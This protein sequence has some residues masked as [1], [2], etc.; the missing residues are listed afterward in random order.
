MKARHR[1]SIGA[2]LLAL[3]ATPVAAEPTHLVWTLHSSVSL[4]RLERLDEE[5]P[6]ALT[7]SMGRAVVPSRTTRTSLLSDQA[8]RRR[9]DEASGLLSQ[10]AELMAE[11][12][13]DEA[14][15]LLES[16][17]TAALD[18]LARVLDAKLLA[19][20]YLQRGIAL[21]PTDQHAA[22]RYLVLSLQHQ[23]VQRFER[24]KY[25]PK[26]MRALQQAAR[27][28]S[29]APLP[30]IGLPE[31]A[32]IA[33]T[34]QVSQLLLA[35]V[36]R[37]GAEEKIGLSRYD[38]AKGGWAW[39]ARVGWP[40]TAGREQIRS[41]IAAELRGRE[42]RPGP[43]ARRPAS[44][45]WAPWIA[46]GVAGASL[47]AGT[48]CALV[49]RARESEAE[50]LA[51]QTPPVEYRPTVKDLEVSGRRLQTA[52]IVSFAVAGAAAAVSATLWLWPSK[53][54]QA[55]V[56]L[57]PGVISVAVRFP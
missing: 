6:R 25:A 38:G 44:R 39:S 33:R 55:Q 13:Y 24:R 31:V 52:A 32:R 4:E 42:E 53:D 9:R 49:S 14:L 35:T 12:R 27:E 46:A 57:G 29:T 2:F 21:L 34:L 41:T 18:G 40:A 1:W 45:R 54:R 5:L 23:P 51:R 10:A 28:A 30:T 26:I 22:R 16:A 3:P 48:V 8:L 43:T 50:S 15:R 7:T 36:Q 56:G 37:S 47:A 20:I 11:M 19:A 17:E